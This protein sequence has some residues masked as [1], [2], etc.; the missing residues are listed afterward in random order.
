MK[1]KHY[2]I[3]LCGG[4]GHHGR[5]NCVCARVLRHYRTTHA[6]IFVNQRPRGLVSESYLQN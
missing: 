6:G 3:S 2:L 5:N 4:R 1:T